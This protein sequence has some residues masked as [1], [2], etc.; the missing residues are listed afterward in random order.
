MIR[1]VFVSDE[2][3]C[4]RGGDGLFVSGEGMVFEL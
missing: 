4:K 1:T 3:V 2:M